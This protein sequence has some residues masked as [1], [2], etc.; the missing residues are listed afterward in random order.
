MAVIAFEGPAGCGKTHRLME[1]LGAM[2]GR[3]PLA[4]HQRVAALTFMHGARRRL[5]A[6]LRVLA[7]LAGR[8]EAT[9]LDSFAWRLV[10]RWQR[11]ALH[12]G[13]AIPA[14]EA[15]TQTCALAAA[16]LD[17]EH[18]RSW[19]AASFPF[20]LVDEAQDL[21]A[22]RSAIVAALAQTATVLLAFD[23]FQCLSPDL[24][25][26][27]IEGWLREHCEPTVLDGCRRTNEDELITAARAVRNG[28]AVNRDGRRFKVMATP[29]QANALAATYL[30]NAI[31][32]RRGGNVAVL[33]PSRQGG[34]AEGAVSRVCQGPVGRHQNG[35]FN[36]E[37]E[38]G[39][40]HNA[41]ALWD[42]LGLGDRGSVE[43]VLA[44]LGA[45]RNEP[46]I[47]TI[48]DW[49]LR[50]RGACGL[51]DIRGDELRRQLDRAVSMRQRFGQRRRAQ[52]SAMT[53]Q[54][55]KNREFDHVIVLW[56]FRIPDD[57]E[58]RR[59]LLY[60]AITRAVRSCT[61][62]V[63]GPALLDAPPFVPRAAQV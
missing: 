56:P 1:E 8:Y 15:Y 12:L 23:E 42:R 5:D 61:V 7:P 36:I 33:T 26:I 31:A 22:E 48:R 28:E 37:W 32:W 40:E 20:V 11:L 47:R 41:T 53:I 34:F 25:P 49:L 44:R 9:T 63:Q 30:A 38:A 16:L 58:Q 59:R 17:R 52:F 45:N 14:E 50:Q 55:A 46:E 10:Q 29:G 35:P 13:H 39:E 21:S 62:L 2:L 3:Q 19:V 51:E 43:D 60:N 54:Q 6:R 57:D 27:A 24:L 4:D 18:V